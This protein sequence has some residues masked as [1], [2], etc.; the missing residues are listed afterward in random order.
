MRSR[1][2]RR[3]AVPIHQQLPRRVDYRHTASGTP[4]S[5]PPTTRS[6]AQSPPTDFLSGPTSW[7]WHRYRLA[8]RAE[9]V[10]WFR[11]RPGIDHQAVVEQLAAGYPDLDPLTHDDIYDLD[12][13]PPAGENSRN[14]PDHERPRRHRTAAVPGPVR[15][16]ATYRAFRH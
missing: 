8:A 5:R 9:D 2:E 16:A 7:E 11:R 6:G 3:D 14:E 12:D 1:H 10:A 4:L 15:I 13:P